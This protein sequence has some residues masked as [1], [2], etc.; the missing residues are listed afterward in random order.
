[1]KFTHTTELTYAMERFCD[2][3]PPRPISQIVSQ[4][5]T[6]HFGMAKGGAFVLFG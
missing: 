2:P 4:I 6:N 3:P 1:M 5:V